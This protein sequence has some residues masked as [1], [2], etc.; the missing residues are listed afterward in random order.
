[1]HLKSAS[2]DEMMRLVLYICTGLN[3]G[4]HFISNDC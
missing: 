1:M 3:G 4:I 2:S